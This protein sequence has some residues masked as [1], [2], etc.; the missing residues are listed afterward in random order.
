MDWIVV[1]FFLCK[2][3]CH[4]DKIP[5]T[6]DDTCLWIDSQ[7]I[8]KVA[9]S[10]VPKVLFWVILWCSLSWATEIH[11]IIS[12]SIGGAKVSIYSTW[13]FFLGIPHKAN[14]GIRFY[15]SQNCNLQQDD[16]LLSALQVGFVNILSGD[17]SD[18]Y[19]LMFEI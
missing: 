15:H 17:S 4:I 7:V 3:N 9:I 13:I 10:Y 8:V 2:F 6:Q 14:S 12:L 5:S 1:L 19:E 11:A 16:A 18:V